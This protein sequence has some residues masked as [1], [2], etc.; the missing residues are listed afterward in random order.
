[1]LTRKTNI[2]DFLAQMK[3]SSLCGESILWVEKIKDQDNTTTLG[4]LADS[5]ELV[6]DQDWAVGCLMLYDGLLDT[7]LR[8]SFIRKVTDSMSAFVLYTKLKTL[9]SEEDRMLLAIFKGKLPTAERELAE[10]KVK[11]TKK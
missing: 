4:Q 5:L 3:A 9:T 7:E 6:K 1:M 10:G 2:Q 8:K 11:R